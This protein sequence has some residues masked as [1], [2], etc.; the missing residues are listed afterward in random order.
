MTTSMHWSSYVGQGA[1][2]FV[3]SFDVQPADISFGQIVIVTKSLEARDRLKGEL[4][5]YLEEDLSRHRRLRQAA[6][7]RSAGR[8]AGPVPR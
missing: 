5:A 7:H 4:Q 2:R 3:L 8:A 6:R 1:P